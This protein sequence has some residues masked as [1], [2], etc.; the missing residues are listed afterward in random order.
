MFRRML[1]QLYI[2]EETY[3]MC[4]GTTRN[5]AEIYVNYMMQNSGNS[6]AM[7]FYPLLDDLTA[8]IDE[9]YGSTEIEAV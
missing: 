1:D 8:W 4:S 5:L 6:D 2:P 7:N 3:E 9:T